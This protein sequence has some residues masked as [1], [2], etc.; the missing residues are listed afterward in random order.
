MNNTDQKIN[1]LVEEVAEDFEL[2]AGYTLPDRKLDE[3]RVTGRTTIDLTD[4]ASIFK[5]IMTY[6][7]DSD[8][9]DVVWYLAIN[10]ISAEVELG[11]K[12]FLLYL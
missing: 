12:G 1:E 4:F 9:N 2:Q 3:L 11:L 6:I 5:P 10:T 8:S 7:R